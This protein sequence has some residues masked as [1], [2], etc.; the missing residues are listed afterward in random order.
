[1]IFRAST[2]GSSGARTSLMIPRKLSRLSFVLDS[3]ELSLIA[4]EGEEG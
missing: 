1:M 4:V 2:S 3:R